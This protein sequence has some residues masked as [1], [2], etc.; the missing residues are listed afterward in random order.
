MTDIFHCIGIQ[1]CDV[2]KDSELK[3]IL[4]E[5]IGENYPS[6]QRIALSNESVEISKSDGSVQF[7]IQTK[8]KRLLNEV[9]TQISRKGNL[10]HIFP[11][12]S[13]IASHLEFFG[14]CITANN[15]LLWSF[16]QLNAEQRQSV[17]NSKC[18]ENHTE[19]IPMFR[20][21]KIFSQM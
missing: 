16:M 15:A 17:L 3:P 13:N 18:D 1:I 6:N 20:A 21:A 5:E 8:H 9:M 7:R 11:L 10:R 2:R 19:S 12:K 4:R 14:K